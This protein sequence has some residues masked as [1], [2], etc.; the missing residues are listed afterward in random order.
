MCYEDLCD[1]TEVWN[2]LAEIAG[3][4]AVWD[5][6]NPLRSSNVRVEIAN[7]LDLVE[8]ASA[9]YARLADRARTAL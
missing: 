6:G 4:T 8:Q 3:I 7:N 5:E 1:G 2:R 9:I